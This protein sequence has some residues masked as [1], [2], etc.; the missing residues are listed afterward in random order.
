MSRRTK[1]LLGLALANLGLGVASGHWFFRVFRVTVPPALVTDFNRATAHGY[2]L[3]H[4][5]LLGAVLF[6]WCL[7][8]LGLWR[9]PWITGGSR[10]ATPPAGGRS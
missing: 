6:L 5:A 2:F 9:L 4:G 7:L 10:D 3:L 8:V 1:A